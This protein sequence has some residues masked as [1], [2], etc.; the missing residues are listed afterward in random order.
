[1]HILLYFTLFYFILFYF[2]LFYFILPCQV[3]VAVRRLFVTMRGLFSSSGTPA[4][5]CAASIVAAHRLS[6][7]GAQ[8]LE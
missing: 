2:I 1:M 7:C 3:L 6:S 4:P 8:A 5:E